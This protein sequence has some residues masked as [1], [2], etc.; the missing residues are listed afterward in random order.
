MLGTKIKFR[1]R[2]C[3]RLIEFEKGTIRT[4]EKSTACSKY[5]RQMFSRPVDKVSPNNT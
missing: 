4:I 5:T 3:N 2:E 1:M